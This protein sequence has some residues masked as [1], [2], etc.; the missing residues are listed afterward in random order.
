MGRLKSTVGGLV[1]FP[2]L[3]LLAGHPLGAQE[4]EEVAPSIPREGEKEEAPPP[5]PIVEDLGDE[6]YRI[7]NIVVEKRLKR[8]TVPG[9]IL[10]EEPPLEFLAVTK[11]GLKA[12]ESL[13]ELETDAYEFNTAC[14]LIGLDPDH[15]RAPRAHFD[16]QPSEGD[17]VDIWISWNENGKAS[18]VEAADLVRRGEMTLP[19]GDWVYTGSILTPEGKYLAQL[20]GTLIGFVHDP[21]SIIEHRAGF[22]MG[23]WGSVGPNPS[24]LPAVG[25]RVTLTVERRG[26]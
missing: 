4:P 8:F 3:L 26:E 20:D 5:A 18:R 7:R 10:R 12:Y 23:D 25:T 1:G 14:I 15:G 16:P 13:V 11:G 2:L 22:G 17:P 21:S 6:R 9:T 24:L 19:R